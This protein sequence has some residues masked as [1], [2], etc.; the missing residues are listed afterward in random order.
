MAGLSESE[1]Y[2]KY[3]YQLIENGEIAF[4]AEAIKELTVILKKKSKQATYLWAKRMEEKR[5]VL[6]IQTDKDD[7]IE[8]LQEFDDE[9]SSDSTE[10]TNEYAEQ[11]S[12]GSCIFDRRERNRRILVFDISK[13][14]LYQ[15]ERRTEKNRDGKQ[16][17]FRAL[18]GWK[19]TIFTFL[20]THTDFQCKWSTKRNWCTKKGIFKI[21]GDCKCGSCIYIESDGQTMKFVVTKINDSFVHNE[22]YHVNGTT[23]DTIAKKLENQ[24]ALSLRTEMVNDFFPDDSTIENIHFTPVLPQ[25]STLQKIKSSANSSNG[26]VIDVLIQRAQ[27]KN[28]DILQV[29]AYP[30]SVFYRTTLQYDWFIA[31][32]KNKRV[33]ISIDATGSVVRAPPRSQKIKNTDKLK[34]VFLYTIMLKTDSAS[35]AINQMLSQQHSHEFICYFLKFMFKN[36][37]KPNEIVLDNSK[38]LI[39]ASVISFTRCRNLSDYIKLCMESIENNASPPE[40]YIRLDRSHFVKNV[41]KK[42]VDR[43]D[44]KQSFY[45]SVIGYLIQCDS[46]EQAKIVISHFFVVLLNRY[47]GTD[48]DGCELP[49]EQSKKWLICLCTTFDFIDEDDK[50]DEEKPDEINEADPEAEELCKEPE[51][52]WLTKI[53]SNAN[54]TELFGLHENLYY[55]PNDLKYYIK[56]FSTICL[57]SNI[58]NLK[59]KSSTFVATSSDVESSFRSLK[60]GILNN[61]IHRVDQF[62][63]KHIKYLNAEIKLRSMTANDNHKSPKLNYDKIFT[64]K[65]M[66]FF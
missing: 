11:V 20:H 24:S 26:D 49:T 9:V 31:E 53:V 39:A 50:D 57:W 5:A 37:K 16:L 43:D 56:L 35:V 63:E 40:C 4:G 27:Q 28:S 61:K 45:R 62:I 3:R 47:D 58:M 8:K 2:E 32:S 15:L 44:R 41:T 13:E 10:K 34:H 46:F 48:E 64:S 12:S 22:R 51:P 19:P 55:N 65:A 7:A 60:H 59:F 21:N 30:F 1:L 29:S 17:R 14:Y 33:S 36:T 18:D 54:T 25:L 23:R 42:I 52:D 38:A 6:S 66:I